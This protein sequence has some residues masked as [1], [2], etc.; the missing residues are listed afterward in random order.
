MVLLGS[1]GAFRML[2]LWASLEV[3]RAL[4]G[5]P[6]CELPFSP[7]PNTKLI[8]SGSLH[9]AVMRTNAGYPA[10]LTPT[11]WEISAGIKRRPCSLLGEIILQNDA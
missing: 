6:D 3:C 4:A 10:P 7:G 9:S 11:S 8:T 2:A 1:V 5:L